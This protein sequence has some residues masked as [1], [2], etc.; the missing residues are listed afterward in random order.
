MCEIRVVCETMRGHIY[1]ELIRKWLCRNSVKR[2]T[3]IMAADNHHHRQRHH[4]HHHH[5]WHY[6][7]RWQP[8]LSCARLCVRSNR[9]AGSISSPFLARFRLGNPIVTLTTFSSFIICIT[10]N[11]SN[12][13]KR[14]PVSTAVARSLLKRH[15]GESFW[16]YHGVQS[17]FTGHFTLKPTR[18]SRCL[19]QYRFS[20]LHGFW[21]NPFNS[22]KE[23]N[24]ITKLQKSLHKHNSGLHLRRSLIIITQP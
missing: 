10:I 12:R 9:T 1:C 5:H 20:L 11:L 6:L 19:R 21:L 3:L 23:I 7:H 22:L 4:H 8:T 24:V 2:V 16:K 14:Y 15:D 13:R 17:D 18:R